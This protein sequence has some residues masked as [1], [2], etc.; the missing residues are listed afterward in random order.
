MITRR[1]LTTPALARLVGYYRGSTPVI[2]GFFQEQSDSSVLLRIDEQGPRLVLS[3]RQQDRDPE[4]M[5]TDIPTEHA[6]VLLASCAGK[7]SFDQSRLALEGG[8]EV[9]VQRFEGSDAFARIGVT[10]P[11]REAADGFVAPIWF[12]SEVT[13]DAAYTNR[14]LALVGIPRLGELSVSDAALDAIMDALEAVP[15][16]VRRDVGQGAASEPPQNTATTLGDAMD[17]ALVGT[18]EDEAVHDA[19]PAD[20]SDGQAHVGAADQR[21]ARSER[22]FGR[23]RAGHPITRAGPGR[24]GQAMEVDAAAGS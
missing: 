19:E 17:D 6:F 5:P 8:Q 18:D 21:L 20:A 24:H 7:L 2:E 11:D 13:D 9:L 1:F 12:G 16:P 10:F 14:G 23:Y 15:E 3:I 4:E 22:R